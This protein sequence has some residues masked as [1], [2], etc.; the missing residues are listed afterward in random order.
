VNKRSQ[1]IKV[2]CDQS[3]QIRGSPTA[4]YERSHKS[5]V[6]D[7]HA[8]LP[9]TDNRSNPEVPHAIGVLVRS[10]MPSKLGEG[11]HSGLPVGVAAFI[12]R[13][14][15][16]AAVSNL[17]ADARV[18]TLTGSGGC[19]KTRLAIVVAGDVAARFPDGACWTDLQG[20]SDAGMVSAAVA[21]AV[22]VHERPDRALVDTLAEQLHA[23]RLL[24]VLDNCE[25][26]V[27]ACAD[28]VAGLLSVCPQLHVLATSRV[29]LAVEGEATFEVA[30]LPVPGPDARSAGTVAVADAAR[31]FEVRARQVRTDF[32]IDADNAVA[33]AEICRRLDGIP[34]A[35]ELA[36]A[37]VRVLAP[38]Q[39]ATGLSDRFGLL[40]SGARGAPA[41]QRTL[42]ASLDWSYDL[43]DDTQR[44]ALARLSVF[45]GSFELDAATAVLARDGI[46]G[47]EVLDLIAALAEQSLLQVVEHDGRARY[48]LLETIRAYARQRLS[49]LDD[50]ARVRDRHL[51]FHVG[52]AGRAHAGLSGGQ[53]EPWMARLAADLDDLRAAMDWAAE[54]GDLKALVDFTEPI[55]RF[56]FEHGLSAEVHRRL[57]DAAA[58]PGARDDE[59]VRGLTT[60]ALLALSGG[61][62]AGAYR[63]A[64]QAINAARSAHVGGALALSLSVR[65]QAGAVSGLSTSEQVDADVE[66]ALEHAEQCDDAAT[67]AFVL[68]IAGWTV[69]RSRT[70]DAGCRLFERVIEVSE[71][72]E[73]TFHLPAA[74]ASLGMWPVFSGRLDRTRRH[75]RRGWELARQIGRPGWEAAGLAGL[76]AAAVLQGDHDQAQDWLSKAEAVLQRPGLEATHYDMF[77]RPWLALSAYASGDLETARATATEIVRIARGR[78]SRWDEPIGELLL[79]VLAHDQQRHDDARAHLEASRA[80]STDPRVPWSLGRS[81]LGLAGLA[82]DDGSLENAWELAHDGLA[83]LDD[84]GDRVG[85]AAALEM[86]AELAVALG[87]PERSLRLLAASQRFHTESGIARFPVQADR[88]SRARNTAHAALDSTDATACWDAGGE[89]ALED[90]VA[91]ARRGRGE[92]QRPQIGWPSLTPAERE[93]VR[94]VAEG[95]TNAEI[96]Q[97][98]FISVNTV[99][100]HLSRVYAKLDVGG[101]ADLAAQVAR[102]DL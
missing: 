26:L 31:L 27:A 101:R 85:A 22:G 55:V 94:L 89:L 3:S 46:D 82:E 49:E 23:R 37:R 28:L 44:L 53:P 56:W 11:V 81:L 12:G 48:R 69:L 60:A 19:G 36:A 95:H 87:E 78:G 45:A 99:K 18:V 1:S 7:V 34:L 70:I 73:V 83:V 75:A 63:S 76:G 52:L 33:V 2:H 13:E 43:L 84:Y 61:E 29:P 96:G 20:V 30:P 32:R 58:A 71:A 38:A 16:R 80:R 25:H 8:L 100:K 92:R 86:I 64:S 14:H 35:I 65:A 93:V 88:F 98:L 9:A 6:D 59:R 62:P 41:R 4:G 54:C 57:H 40:T 97:R 5:D 50:P 77:L 15:E 68:A 91:Y 17:V 10:R 102:R 51:A 42:E 39:I 74:H 90:A 67:H 66:E 79:G 47:N 21:R 72:A 24:V